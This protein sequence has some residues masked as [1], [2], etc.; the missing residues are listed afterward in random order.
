MNRKMVTTMTS[1]TFALIA[2]LRV[3]RLAILTVDAKASCC[4]LRSLAL[5]NISSDVGGFE[6]TVVRFPTR[7]ERT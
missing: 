3:A 7:R 1:G 2:V 5:I 4:V 6:N